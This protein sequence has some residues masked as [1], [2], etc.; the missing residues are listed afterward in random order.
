MLSVYTWGEGDGKATAGV[1]AYLFSA[2]AADY[3]RREEP[4]WQAWLQAL[5]VPD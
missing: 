1:R 4:I 2:D 5:S 3:V